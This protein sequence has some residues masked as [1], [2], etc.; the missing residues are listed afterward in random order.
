MECCV[1]DSSFGW[2]DR[3]FVALPTVGEIV[4]SPYAYNYRIRNRLQNY[5][6]FTNPTI[7]ILMLQILYTCHFSGNALTSRLPIGDMEESGVN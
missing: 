5:S 6:F 2:K 4:L 1:V 7:C 3:Y